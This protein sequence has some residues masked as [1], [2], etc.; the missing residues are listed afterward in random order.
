MLSKVSSLLKKEKVKRPPTEEELLASIQR[1]LAAYDAQSDRNDTPT[2]KVPSRF[3]VVR[4]SAP[5]IELV[6][7]E[8]S[9]IEM[10]RIIEE[11]VT[12]TWKTVHFN[13]ALT[14]IMFSSYEVGTMKIGKVTIEMIRELEF[15]RDLH[16]GIK[17]EEFK[18][19]DKNEWYNGHE[20]FAD[21]STR[22]F[23]V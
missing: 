4:E 9:D 19:W 17:P 22:R 20:T 13:D 3:G 23:R 2:K 11:I 6:D 16:R 1:K 8:P 5:G 12:R 10:N 15:L 18:K 7:G 21:P 14:Q